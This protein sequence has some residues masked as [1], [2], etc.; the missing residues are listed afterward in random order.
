MQRP[1][2]EVALARL[3]LLLESLRWTY[4]MTWEAMDAAA[5]WADS[6]SFE[7][8]VAVATLAEAVPR[9]LYGRQWR[10]PRLQ[11][12]AP[13]VWVAKSASGLAGSAEAGAALERLRVWRFAVPPRFCAPKELVWLS[14]Q[15]QRLVEAV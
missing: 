15:F 2:A 9:T 13:V 3:A 5:T 12:W 1:P 8:K 6:M 14:W 7:A 11:R 10:Q 4:R